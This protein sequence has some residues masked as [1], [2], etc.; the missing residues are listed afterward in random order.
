M[1]AANRLGCLASMVFGPRWH[2]LQAI[3]EGAAAATATPV[4]F[5]W[6]TYGGILANRLTNWARRKVSRPVRS[7]HPR[8]VFE[9]GMTDFE[10]FLAA[11]ASGESSLPHHVY[12][13]PRS[14]PDRA[15]VSILQRR[16]RAN[17]VLHQVEPPASYPRKYMRFEDWEHSVL[18]MLAASGD[19]A[20]LFP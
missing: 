1:V 9:A 15:V 13:C 14:K 20:A 4:A 16:T 19:L 12:Y 6:A 10:P 7:N 3:G 17:L 8:C 18:P 2:S 11:L 5:T